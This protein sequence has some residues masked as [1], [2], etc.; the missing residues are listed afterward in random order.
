MFKLENV[1]FKY[2]KSVILFEKVNFICHENK[3]GL[4]GANGSGKTT[5]LK[6]LAHIIRP[7]EGKIDVSS[8]SYLSVYDFTNYGLFTMQDFLDLI[9]RLQSFN[10]V[11]LETHLIGLGI[12]KYLHYEIKTLS[13]GTKKKLGILCTF[14]SSRDILLIDEPFESVDESSIAYIEKIITASEKKIIVVEHN[15]QRLKKMMDAVI[16]IDEIKRHGV[17]QND[18]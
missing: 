5:L 13:Q 7:D 4:I 8:S 10:E 6:L 12:K 17:I 14:L 15:K 1:S 2:N 9:L 18:V 16:E 3:L 11:D